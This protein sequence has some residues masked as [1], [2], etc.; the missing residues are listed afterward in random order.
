MGRDLQFSM[1]LPKHSP[2][3]GSVLAPASLAKRLATHL[4]KPPVLPG[5]PLVL[6]LHRELVL[7]GT[8][9]QTGNSQGDG[10][11]VDTFD[12]ASRREVPFWPRGFNWSNLGHSVR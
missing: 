3:V 11:E 10:V 6:W 7:G 9:V 1:A 8:V 12:G 4:G 2:Q 5:H